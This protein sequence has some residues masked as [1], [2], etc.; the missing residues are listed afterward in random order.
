MNEL[1]YGSNPEEKIVAVHPSSDR[2]MRLYKRIDDK[3]VSEDANFY[4]FFFISNSV[5]LKNF[6][7]KHWIKELSGDNYFRYLAAFSCWSEMWNGVHYVLS[8]Y[9]ENAPSKISNY[10]ELPVI[11]LRTDPVAQFLKQTGRTLFKGMLFSDLHRLQIDIQIN[12]KSGNKTWN[13]MRPEDRILVITLKSNFGF[14]KILTCRRKSEKDILIEF[15]KIINEIDPDV[16]EGY[17]L[18]NYVLPYIS[19]RCELHDI[20]FAIGRDGS[21]PRFLENKFSSHDRFTEYFSIEIHGRH[22]IDILHLVQ[23]HA[24]RRISPADLSIKSI[25]SSLG[26]SPEIRTHLNPIQVS[27]VWDTEPETVIE[28]SKNNINEIAKISSL[29]S[30]KLFLLTQIV[31]FNY[32][33]VAR[34]NISTKIESIVLREYIR[35]KHSVP[36]PSTGSTSIKNYEE[37]F[38]QGIFE[39]VICLDIE[40]IFPNLMMENNLNFKHDNLNAF[41]ELL[42]TL[43]EIKKDMENDLSIMNSDHYSVIT[44]LINTFYEY[45]GNPRALFNDFSAHDSITNQ[46]IELIQKLITLI[47]D[48]GGTVLMIDSEQAYIVPPASV[49][50]I[51]EESLFVSNI[52]NE[53]GCVICITIKNRFKRMFSYK[54]R[55]YALISYDDKIILKGSGFTSRNLEPFGRHFIRQAVEAL[56]QKDFRRLHLIFCDYK[57]RILHHKIPIRLLSKTEILRDNA[58]EYSNLIKSGR[59]NKTTGYEVALAAGL[60]WKS[61]DVISYYVAGA[62]E[63]RRETEKFKLTEEWDVNSPDEDVDYYIKRLNEFAKKFELL[64]NEEDFQNIFSESDLFGFSPA[65][66]RL[67]SRIVESEFQTRYEEEPEQQFSE[68]RILLDEEFS[69]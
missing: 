9:N 14:E 64:F 30:S 67:Q 1:L 24:D 65:D 55:N 46:S 56:L 49:S 18:Y 4:P 54:K 43:F 22:V 2:S 21:V 20:E 44:S 47:N 53:L 8:K 61:G 41:R 34:T 68:P 29:L 35:Q 26:L 17:D 62:T 66:I 38:Y 11:H 13:P 23:L 19:S 69:E 33:T 16:I 25:S 58:D 6:P 12:I 7:H 52:S 27:R 42:K 40:S 15:T 60:N 50:D 37:I 10:H 59:R 48:R 31:P 45:T 5:Y 3:I 28:N 39:P 51:E 32:D 36:R 63:S 57:N